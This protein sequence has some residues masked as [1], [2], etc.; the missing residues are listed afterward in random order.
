MGWGRP[1]GKLGLRGRSRGAGAESQ[2][3]PAAEGSVTPWA[4]IGGGGGGKAAAG[5]ESGLVSCLE[6]KGPAEGSGGSSRQAHPCLSPSHTSLLLEKRGN[7]EPRVGQAGLGPQVG[8][9]G[10]G[11]WAEFTPLSR[12]LGSLSPQVLSS[13]PLL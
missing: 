11:G 9:G 3:P 12:S 2:G 5:W 10:P 7:C 4:R 1:R 13:I 8:R 6:G